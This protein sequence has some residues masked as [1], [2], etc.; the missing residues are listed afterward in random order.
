[1]PKQRVIYMYAYIVS[2]NFIYRH[3]TKIHPLFWVIRCTATVAENNS[4]SI[5][6]YVSIF[7]PI[8]Y[9]KNDISIYL[10]MYFLYTYNMED[11]HVSYHNYE[12][13]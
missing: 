3:C 1:M 5:L 6:N 12:R 9:S 13:W 10:K 8:F 7:I 11:I 4:I 2:D